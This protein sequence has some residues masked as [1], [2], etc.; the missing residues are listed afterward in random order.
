MHRRGSLLI[1]MKSSSGGQRRAFLGIDALA[2]AKLQDFVLV[3]ID[4]Q[5]PGE[6]ET[7]SFRQATLKEG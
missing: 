6:L 4:K 5:S 1:K 3:A 7:F 2:V